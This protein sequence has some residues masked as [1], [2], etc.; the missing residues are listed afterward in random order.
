MVNYNYTASEKWNYNYNV[1]K[2]L[3]THIVIDYTIVIELSPATNSYFVKIAL[4]NQ[5][6]QSQ[7]LTV[8]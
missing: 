5:D 6:N 3:I 1:L 8:M 2:K 4:H 7:H